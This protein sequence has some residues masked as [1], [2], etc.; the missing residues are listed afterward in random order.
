MKDSVQ[1]GL[2]IALGVA[3]AVILLF[4]AIYFSENSITF[5]HHSGAPSLPQKT[6]TRVIIQKISDRLV[7]LLH[8]LR[9]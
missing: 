1:R 8:S 2:L 4:S 9:K 6:D 3:V 5:Q 7:P